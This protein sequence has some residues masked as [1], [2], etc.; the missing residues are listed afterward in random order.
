MQPQVFGPGAFQDIDLKSAFDAVS[1]FSQPVLSSSNHGELMSLALKNAIIERDVAHLIFPDDVQTLPSEAPAKG[2]EGRMGGRVVS[3]SDEDL[4]KA[5]K[6]INAAKRPIIVL[7]YGAVEARDK[8]IALAE[9]LGAPV[10]T[11]FKGKGLIADTHHNAAG[12]LGRSG[13]PIA[14]WFMNESDLILSLGSSFGNHTGIDRSK[15]IIQVDFDPMQL[16]KFH[17]VALPIWGEIGA[18]CDAI[19]GN[20][21]K[22]SGAADQISELVE[23]WKIWR[24]EKE[25]R[26]AET[27]G[28]GVHSAAVFKALTEL[29]P[30]EAAT[31][32]SMPIPQWMPSSSRLERGT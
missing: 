27:R 4:A 12:V 8:V 13:T 1:R 3:P 26:L 29:A 20:V 24:A 2:P 14:S 23:R 30:H 5:A 21:S 17:P 19:S 15:T 9:K 25:T 32:A 22:A 31:L 11:T 28:K 7:G 16:G 10:L 6:M 18:F